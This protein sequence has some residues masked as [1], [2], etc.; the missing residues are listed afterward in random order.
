MNGWNF[1]AA[2]VFILCVWSFLLGV[3]VTY[4]AM[5]LESR[6]AVPWMHIGAGCL[7]AAGSL[8]WWVASARTQR[9]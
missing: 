1:T 8:W 6:T 5:N 7:L 3:W 4:L 2:P 9:E